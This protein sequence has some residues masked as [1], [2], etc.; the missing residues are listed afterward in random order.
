MSKHLTRELVAGAAEV[1]TELLQPVTVD[2]SFELPRGLY[3][4]TAAA[5]LGFLAVLA[6]GL[7]SPGLVI[8]LS[9]CAFFIAMAVGVPAIW[10]R[11]KPDNRVAAMSWARFRR[12]GIMTHTGRLSSGEAAAQ[13]LVLPILIFAWG[14][15]C[16][17]IAAVV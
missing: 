1:R 10:T 7:S 8:P 15:V 14:I 5:Y 16:V 17:T 4:A 3:V 11:L 6:T 2:R 9:I 12:Q 13:M